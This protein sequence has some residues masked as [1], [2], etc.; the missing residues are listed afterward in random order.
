M[1]G[2]HGRE[3]GANKKDRGKKNPATFIFIFIFIVHFIRVLIFIFIFILNM[4]RACRCRRDSTVDDSSFSIVE[5]RDMRMSGFFLV[6]DVDR[7]GIL[8]C[9][10]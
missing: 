7:F 6:F 10:I 8:A 9:L 1:E 2:T 4:D 3:E 5:S